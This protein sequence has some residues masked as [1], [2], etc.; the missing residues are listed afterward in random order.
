MM[1]RGPAPWELWRRFPHGDG[2]AD[3]DWLGP[4]LQLR[5]TPAP[6]ALDR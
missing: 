2:P 6:E 5:S 4:Q 3:K 1:A